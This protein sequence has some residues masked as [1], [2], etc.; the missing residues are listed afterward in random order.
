MTYR[1]LFAILQLFGALLA[2]AATSPIYINRGP[3][4]SPPDVAPQIDALA[5][6]NESIFNVNGYAT[7]G[8]YPLPYQTLNTRSFT[9]NGAMMGD[10]GFRFDNFNGATRQW[11]SWWVNNGDIYCFNTNLLSI[12]L[13]VTRGNMLLV[14]AT[15]IVNNGYLGGDDQALIQ[16]NGKNVDLSGSRIRSGMDLEQDYFLFGTYLLST[17]YINDG[18]IYDEWWG[19]GQNNELGDQGDLMPLNGLPL[20]VPNFYL[21]TPISPIHEV[22]DV[23]GYTNTVRVP[24]YNFFIPGYSNYFVRGYAA[25]V[26]TNEINATSRVV[27]VVF[28]PTNTD[29]N[30]T[31]DVRFSTINGGD[32]ATAVV[33]FHVT[34]NDP[35]LDL[36]YTNSLYLLDGIAFRTNLVL[37]R[38]TQEGTRKPNTLM[39][40]RNTPYQY[41]YGDLPNGVYDPTL[42]NSTNFMSNQVSVT[43]AGYAAMVD[44]INYTPP[45]LPVLADP[46]NY[47]GRVEIWGDQVNLGGTSIRADSTFM[48]KATNLVGNKFAA[49]NAPVLYFDVGSTQP[50]LLISNLAPDSVNRMSGEVYC[51]SAVWQNY[52]TNAVATNF[53]RFHVLMVDHYLTSV[54][55][56]V[57]NQFG[58]RVTNGLVKISDQL[59]VYKKFQIVAKDLHVEGGINFPSGSSW[60]N[61]NLV[62]V[63]NFT[64]DGIIQLP[65]VANVGTD[66]ASPYASYVNRGTNLATSHY[67]RSTYFEN[68][69]WISSSGGLLSVTAD[70]AKLHGKQ[71]AL[72]STV[73]TNWM[74]DRIVGSSIILITNVSTNL[75]TNSFNAALVANSGA[76]IYANSL[77]LSNAYIQAGGTIAGTLTLSITNKLTDSGPSATNTLIASGG[78]QML[79]RPAISRLLGTYLYSKAG[80]AKSVSH[81]WPATNAG[82]TI[83]GFSNNLALGKLTLD[84]LTNSSFIFSGVGTNCALYVD[85][86]ELLNHATNYNLALKVDPSITIYF[87]HANIPA[88]KLDGIENG[89]VRWVKKYT[90]PLS[91][92]NIAYVTSSDPPVTNIYTFNISLVQNKDRDDDGDGIVN[93][94]DPTP[95]YKGETVCLAVQNTKRTESNGGKQVLLS[96]QALGQAVS[97]LEYRPS[98]SATDSWQV[99]QVFTNNQ[100]LTQ[101]LTAYDALTNRNQRC[102]RVRIEVPSEP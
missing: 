45:A 88:S 46:T 97:Y 6:V 16:L 61:T 53:I 77:T 28:Y 32:G 34:D 47:P 20:T 60:G 25:A 79:K 81:V 67:I 10:P 26:Y 11:M 69:E 73:E 65:G 71:M 7:Y 56:V 75:V 43:Y 78:V 58:A 74:I 17:N 72:V 90:G 86:L 83:V 48:L 85:Y 1:S 70:S 14:S 9:N 96:W 29:A 4:Q 52:E 41:Y 91:S 44:S 87:A 37:A 95:I 18:G 24:Y 21:P 102:Y 5:F 93:G 62:N 66:R 59:N 39:L 49:V 31:T 51:W 8:Y 101:P 35:V 76:Q 99:L 3:V 23:Y 68:T 38:N 50:Q 22:L 92:T 82:A 55:P 42:L 94:D 36:T 84:G 15:N 98:L 19:V 13:G 57:V 33:G 64:N 30:I 2:S 54:Q 40:T 89:H 27:Q 12:V 100:L 63:M 80:V